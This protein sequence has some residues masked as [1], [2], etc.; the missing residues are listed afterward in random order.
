MSGAAPTLWMITF[1]AGSVFFF[2]ILA[3]IHRIEKLEAKVE[4]IETNRRQLHTTVELM[5]HREREA[6]P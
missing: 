3:L 2:A 5:R 6:K 4:R 1:A